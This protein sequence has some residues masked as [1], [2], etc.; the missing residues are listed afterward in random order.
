MLIWGVG[1]ALLVL[2]AL[3]VAWLLTRPDQLDD[4]SLPNHPVLITPVVAETHRRMPARLE[5]QW[6][7]APVLRSP[8]WSGV[9]IGVHLRPDDVVETGSRAIQVNGI[10][11]LVLT[12]SDPF[13]RPLGPRDDGPD[14]LQLQ[15]FLTYMGYLD[16]EIDGVYGTG[17]ADAVDAFAEEIGV[18]EPNG[19]FDPSWLVVAEQERFRVSEVIVEA[20]MAAPGLGEP[21]AIGYPA[22]ER[23][24]LTSPDGTPLEMTDASEPHVVDIAGRR[25][26][27]DLAAAQVAT[28]SL[29]PLSDILDAQVEAL[30]VVLELAEPLTVQ[31][32][33]ASAVMSNL[34]G[35]TCIWATSPTGFQPRSVTIMGSSVGTARIR[36]QS[37]DGEQ[38]LANPAVI[39]ADPTCP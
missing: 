34:S 27:V 5:L 3:L 6:A 38:I 39:L 9:V 33:P 26:A 22:L 15:Q 19:R 2:P 24:S 4:L 13:Y 8:G 16:G 10:D 20:G 11:R 1:F 14:V 32:V 28:D 17:T 31:E 25:F 36:G 12:G 7:A 21:I 30:D 18:S 35:D 37:A 23:A 29:G